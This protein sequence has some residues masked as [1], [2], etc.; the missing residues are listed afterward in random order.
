MADHVAVL[1]KEVV[2]YL[3]PKKGKKI[4]DATL[5][6]GG[7]TKAF[8]KKKA[9]VLS[10]E[11]DEQVY[12]LTKKHLSCPD[13]SWKIVLG[14][15]AD[16]EKIGR[17]NGFFPVGAILFDLGVSTW[18]Y[19]KSQRGFS[20]SD[21]SLDMR[22]SSKTSLTAEKIVN[23]GS[24]D[25]LRSI[26]SSLVQQSRA[27][28]IADQIIK[29][30]PIRSAIK[31]EKIVKEVTGQTGK[32][33]PATKIF[34]A[35]RIAV[36]S[37]LDNLVSGLMGAVNL[38]EIGGKLAVISFHSGEDRIVKLYFKKLVNLGKIK[39]LTKKAVRP[40][41]EEINKNPSARSALLRVVEKT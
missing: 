19:K 20:F 18:H 34:L 14:N 32:I 15:F 16:I 40:S 36:N 17:E 22:I 7:H 39:I 6:M 8:L 26:F 33:N 25:E 10:L 2:E 11:W 3:E 21:Q 27:E 23:S 4:I 37:E 35:L 5:G 41:R 12:S 28:K 38:L 30:R 1:L 9:K 29:N 31:L 24:K 13:A